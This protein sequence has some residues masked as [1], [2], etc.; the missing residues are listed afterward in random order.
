MRRVSLR[1][2]LMVSAGLLLLAGPLQAQRSLFIIAGPTFAKVSTNEYPTKSRMGFFA[3]VGTSLQLNEKLSIQPFVTYAE[4]GTKFTDDETNHTY[5]YFEIPVLLATSLPLSDK[6]DLAVSLGPRVSFN[7]KC[8]ET[9][10]GD[11][12]YNCKN[13]DGYNGKTEFGA[14]G[15]VGLQFPVGRSTMGVG[16]G[17]DL[18]LTDFYKNTDGG[19]KSHAFFIFLSYGLPF[20]ASEGGGEG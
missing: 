2:G 4:K 15:S 6:M 5:S 19:W 14:L 9:Y 18:S 17:Y 12:N 8:N 13:Y 11:P 3:G 16:G 7:V 10:P 20:G 1:E